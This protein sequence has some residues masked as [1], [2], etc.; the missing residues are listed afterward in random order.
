ME[1]VVELMY[2]GISAMF[3]S[4]FGGVYAGMSIFTMYFKDLECLK[5]HLTRVTYVGR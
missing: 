3:T 1:V 5:A 4:D 2:K